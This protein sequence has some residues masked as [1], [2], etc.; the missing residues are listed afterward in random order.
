MT[1]VGNSASH[2]FMV[3]VYIRK[4]E[5]VSALL[6][7]IPAGSIPASETHNLKYSGLIQEKVHESSVIIFITKVGHASTDLAMVYVETLTGIFRY[8]IFASLLSLEM[9]PVILF[10]VPSC[11]QVKSDL[12]DGDH[13]AIGLDY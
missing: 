12:V 7:A 3:Y 8:Q 13:S 2:Q 1:R 10:L 4:A 11:A 9:G 6:S 5:T